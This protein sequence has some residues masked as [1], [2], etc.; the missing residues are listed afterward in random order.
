MMSGVMMGRMEG[1][2]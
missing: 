1:W 2:N